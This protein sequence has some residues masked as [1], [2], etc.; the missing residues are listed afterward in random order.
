M[1]K[2]VEHYVGLL[3][4]LFEKVVG[5]CVLCMSVLN[6]NTSI[7]TVVMPGYII[8]RNKRFIL[9]WYPTKITH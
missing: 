3:F 1:C 5:I 2:I 8:Y 4:P 6:K 9:S 7:F